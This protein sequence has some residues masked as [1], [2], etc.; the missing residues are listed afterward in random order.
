VDDEPTIL[1]LLSGSLRFAGLL[2]ALWQDLG[3]TMVIV[4]HDTAVARR[5]QQ[6]GVMKEGRLDLKLAS[7]DART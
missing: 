1:E 4:T 3:L 5:A 2:E 7:R 6:T